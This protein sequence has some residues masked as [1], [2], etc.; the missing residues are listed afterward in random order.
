MT[1]ITKAFGRTDEQ[2]F[3]FFQ[4]QHL[5]KVL[6]K[7][8]DPVTHVCFMDEIIKVGGRLVLANKAPVS[9]YCYQQRI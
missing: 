8:R 6:M 5:Q 1:L 2:V 7:K 9:P 4:V 3:A